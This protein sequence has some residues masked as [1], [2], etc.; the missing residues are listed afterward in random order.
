M[1]ANSKLAQIA[2]SLAAGFDPPFAPSL[3]LSCFTAFVQAID[4][5]VA[6]APLLEPK[7]HPFW[8]ALMRFV[9]A[10]WTPRRQNEAAH[11]LA[12]AA[13]KCHRCSSSRS[14][15]KIERRMPDADNPFDGVFQFACAKVSAAL[16]NSAN[17]YKGFGEHHRRW[18]VRKE[19]L[20]PYGPEA[21]V[22]SLVERINK[23]P[24]AQRLTGS[25]LNFHRPIVFP[26]LMQEGN[27]TRVTTC[28]TGHLASCTSAVKAAQAALPQ[29]AVDDVRDA[30]LRKH[31]ESCDGVLSLL[32][33]ITA[34]PDSLAGDRAQFYRNNEAAL[35][36][37][38]HDLASLGTIHERDKYSAISHFPTELWALLS[39][40]QR[41]EFGCR[42]LPAYARNVETGE[43]LQQNPYRALR[44]YLSIRPETRDCS[45]PGCAKTVHEPG[46][47]HAFAKCAKCRVVQYCS[48]ACQKADWTGLPLPHKEVC[49]ALHELSTFATWDTWQM[50]ADE[51][52][53]AC[54]EHAYPLG[55]VDKL[56]YWATGGNRVTGYSPASRPPRVTSVFK[57]KF[58][59]KDDAEIQG[60]RCMISFPPLPDGRRV[61]ELELKIAQK[62]TR[63]ILEGTGIVF[64]F[65]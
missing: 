60:I 20:F 43:D 58:T 38:F 55:R 63:E 65:V 32:V 5:P 47:R 53:A 18:P 56:I 40:A 3:C 51:F 35:F 62:E 22:S 41:L 30:V 7:L 37:A 36:R 25:L 1:S 29:P 28:I 17:R 8:D 26:I 16:C 54:T 12:I 61:T 49:D 15:A 13:R 2:Q 39:E 57:P 42:D 52:C 19:Q 27:R 46:M 64:S 44:Y 24:P 11:L 23:H 48:R 9:A 31:V 4:S 34:G 21:T 10:D 33:A 14:R 6:L 50:T 45:A 59:P